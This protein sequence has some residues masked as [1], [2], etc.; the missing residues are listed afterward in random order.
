MTHGDR[1]EILLGQHIHIIEF[2]PPSA[3][4]KADPKESA[5][6]NSGQAKKLHEISASEDEDSDDTPV[7]KKFKK[8]T[9][10]Q[11]EASGAFSTSCW[12]SLDGGK[13]LVF[14]PEGVRARSAIAAYDLDGTIIGTTSGGVFPKHRDD[15]K[16][17]YP[18]ILGRL[19]EMHEKKHKIIFF[20]NQAGLSSGKQDANDFKRK[21]ENIVKKLLLPIQVFIS[22]SYSIYRKPCTGMWEAALE[23]N[24]GIKVDMVKS[25]YCGD[26]AGR[27][28]EMTNA[29]KDF[30]H[31]DLLFAKNLQLH[32]VTPEHHFLDKKMPLLKVNVFDPNAIPCDIPL[33]EPSWGQVISNKTEVIILVGCPG[34]GKSHFAKTHLVPAGYV[35][36]NRDT[37]GT[38][39]KCVSV[40]EQ[41]LRNRQR[42]VIDNTNPDAESRRRYIDVAQNFTSLVRCFIMNTSLQHAKHNNKV[43]I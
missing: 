4:T 27:T 18:E 20:T 19:K 1:I 31:T 32:F 8:S 29:K 34:S 40:T 11:S 16:I 43:R 42:V 38:F 14:T 7:A 2:D 39:N 13:L 28:A 3:E 24:E 35:H 23:R 25:F 33:C 12:E 17:L 9:P 10:S 22:T 37:L 26:A 41:A 36:V 15:W 6:S 21:I 30:S 5:S